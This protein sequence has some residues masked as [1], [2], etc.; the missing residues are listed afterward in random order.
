[1]GKTSD[2]LLRA[3]TPFG[4]GIGG[5]REEVCG[6]LSGG[7]LVL[8]ALMGRTLPTEDNEHLRALVRLLRDRFQAALGHTHCNPIRVAQPTDSG[9]RCE[10]VVE[11]GARLVV[12]LIEDERQK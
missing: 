5:C 6:A 1:M 10:L 8:G 9:R 4:G 12:E 2:L 11:Q 7:V 3:S